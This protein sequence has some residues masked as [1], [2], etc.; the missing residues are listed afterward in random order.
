MK[1]GQ[2]LTDWASDRAA[3]AESEA[4]SAAAARAW[5]EH[6]ARRRI[7]AALDGDDIEAGLSTLFADA[8]WL[9]TLL[10]P[11]VAGL[12]R[13]PFFQPPLRIGGDGHRMGM[14]L[15]RDERATVTLSVIRLGGGD[16][17]TASA[18]GRVQ[19]LH[20]IRAGGASIELRPVAGGPASLCPIEDGDNLRIDGRTT[21]SA[22]VGQ[23]ST[24]ILLSASLAA[25]CSQAVR[26]FDR[27]T[28]ALLRS[29]ATD[30]ADPRTQLL[31]S[32]LRASGRANAADCF[33][34]AS[35]G[36][37]PGLRWE[38]MR[39]WLLTDAATALPRL[40][41]MATGDPDHDVRGAAAA[42]LDRAR[43][44]CPA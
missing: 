32:L 28:G 1:P 8:A 2:A 26:I 22:L 23:Q 42:T 16:P 3:Q 34:E 36:A 40:A 29:S 24:V 35:Y 9:P 7:D 43:Q 19:L 10:D 17:A 30:E 13:D 44:S 12:A 41:E 5:G 25:D 31:L 39:E 27:A 14:V 33:A 38:A 11:L 18:A 20:I 15:A 6:P 21:A 4:R 37:A